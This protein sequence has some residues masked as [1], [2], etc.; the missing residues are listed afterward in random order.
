MNPMRPRFAAAALPALAAATPQAQHAGKC[1][2]IPKEELKP[3]IDLERKPTD[4]GWKIGRVKITDGCYEVYGHDG[5]N[6]KVE[7]F[8]HPKTFE[9]VLEPARPA[10]GKGRTWSGPW[11]GA[12]R[13]QLAKAMSLDGDARQPR[14][15]PLDPRGAPRGP[16]ATG[17]FWSLPRADGHEGPFMAG[18]PT[19]S[20]SEADMAVRRSVLVLRAH[21]T[22]ERLTSPRRANRCAAARTRRSRRRRRRRS[23]VRAAALRAGSPAV[24][25]CAR[26]PCCAGR[27]RPRRG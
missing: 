26:R 17:S 22:I 1:S 16:T 20:C 12:T 23:S 6:A 2:P 9:R 3:Q 8:C 27:C 19:S 5:K 13:P 24:R 11:S 14:A 7:V 21:Q 4:R 25:A 10:C 15:S 18:G